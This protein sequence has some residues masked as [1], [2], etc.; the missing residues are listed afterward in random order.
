MVRSLDLRYVAIPREEGVMT[1]ARLRAIY[2]Q[3]ETDRH[4]LAREIGYKPNYLRHIEYGR[5]NPSQRFDF[6][7]DMWISR[8]KMMDMEK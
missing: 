8:R 7:V 3:Y 6:A 4:E 2:D 1:G 5:K